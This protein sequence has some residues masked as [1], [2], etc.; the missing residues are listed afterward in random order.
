MRPQH[1]ISNLKNQENTCP[2]S[3]VFIM[4]NIFYPQLSM[5]DLINEDNSQQCALIDENQEDH[6]SRNN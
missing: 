3:P 1:K 4:G 6:E 2:N 5:G